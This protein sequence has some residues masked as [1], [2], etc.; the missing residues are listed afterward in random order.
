ML[1]VILSTRRHVLAA[2]VFSPL[3]APVIGWAA[4]PLRPAGKA[5]LIPS[6]AAY[7]LRQFFTGEL[8]KRIAPEP[9]E[10]GIDLFGFIDYCATL[11]CAAELTGYFLPKDLS[12]DV[13]QRIR[14]HAFLRGVAISGSAIG[15]NFALP[16]GS[17]RDA[18]IAKAK[19]WIDS[20]VKIGAPHVRV[21]GGTPAKDADLA[22]IRPLCIAA[23]KECA[24]YAGRYGIV[25]G[26]ENHGGLTNDATTT[27][28]L[29]EA[30]GSPWLGINLDSG[31]FHSDDPYRDFA[32]CAAQAVNVQVK[33]DTKR[34]GADHEDPT[35]YARVV[36][37]LREANYQGFVA[38]EYEAKE[39]PWTAIPREFAKMRDACMA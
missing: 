24:E 11:G 36:K 28:A 2:A 3:L 5:R 15:N 33:V 9:Q 22:V 26:L 31:N 21:F 1:P 7:S 12:G 34:Q 20:S 4:E 32:R 35:E 18:E 23:L 16:L 14:R 13:L 29:A 27:L 6:L 17:A 25:L 8:Q 38:L 10:R 37:I 19:E 30:V 39:D